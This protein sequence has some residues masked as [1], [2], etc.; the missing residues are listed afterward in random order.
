MTFM[1]FS[2]ITSNIP[3]IPTTPTA[4]LSTQWWQFNTPHPLA[5]AVFPSPAATAAAA[6]TAAAAVSG[7]AQ[8]L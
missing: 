1:S 7:R 5:I 6:T 2:I 4:H 3:I 8:A